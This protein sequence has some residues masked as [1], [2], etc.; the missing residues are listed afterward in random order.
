MLSHVKVYVGEGGEVDVSGARG[1]GRVIIIPTGLPVAKQW[2]SIGQI[3][4]LC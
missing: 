4:K 3:R 2:Y 1:K